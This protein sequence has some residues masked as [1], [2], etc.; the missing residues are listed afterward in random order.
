MDYTIYDVI[1]SQIKSKVWIATIVNIRATA[2]IKTQIS[3]IFMAIS[4]TYSTY[5]ITFGNK[6]FVSTSKR[7]PF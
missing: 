7:W 5:G 2:S 6:K 3:E 1:G 4:L